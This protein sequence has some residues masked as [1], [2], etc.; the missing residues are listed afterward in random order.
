MVLKRENNELLNLS[1]KKNNNFLTWLSTITNALFLL[2]TVG[3]ATTELFMF[4]Y[5]LYHRLSQP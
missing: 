2:L 3:I 1:E 5:I 4:A